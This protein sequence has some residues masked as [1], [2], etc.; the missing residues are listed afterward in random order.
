VQ[1]PQAG[2]WSGA[3]EQELPLTAVAIAIIRSGFVF[4]QGSLARLHTLYVCI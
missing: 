1:G 2:N 4:A 3:G